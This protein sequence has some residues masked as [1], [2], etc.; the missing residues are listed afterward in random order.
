MVEEA[1]LDLVTR[2]LASRAALA[3]ADIS[4]FRQLPCHIR[5]FQAGDCIASATL[6]SD[7]AAVLLEGFVFGEA[8]SRHKLRQIVCLHLPGDMVDLHGA[9][10]GSSAQTIIAMTDCKMAM[11]SAAALDRLMTDRPRIARALWIETL[12]EA[13]VARKWVMNLGQRSARQRLAHLCCELAWRSHEAGIGDGTSFPV[14]FS[15]DQFA[16]ATGL[17]R[18]N[19]NQTLH[20]LEAEGLIVRDDRTIHI[21][22]EDRLTAEAD[23]DE[24]Y[25]K[26]RSDTKMPDPDSR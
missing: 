18:L 15:P 7:G 17:T 9:L 19:V 1:V 10:T 4:A 13:A 24:A 12:M 21:L 14:P 11:V 2:R 6:P 22:D 3:P 20:R 5:E 16:D 25:L 8:G 26:V 23:F